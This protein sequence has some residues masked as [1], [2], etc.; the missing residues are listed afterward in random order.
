M[1]VEE[2]FDYQYRTFDRVTDEDID[3]IMAI[4]DL[5]GDEIA[6]GDV[7]YRFLIMGTNKKIQQNKLVVNT[8]LDNIED[9]I[10]NNKLIYIP[11]SHHS[12]PRF[13]RVKKLR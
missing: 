3:D 10:I 7:L 5:N 2:I 13:R 4:H 1:N 6:P 12:L 8:S 9:Y 11:T